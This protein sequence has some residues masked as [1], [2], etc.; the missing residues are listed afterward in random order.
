[1]TLNEFIEKVKVENNITYPTKN[2]SSYIIECARKQKEGSCAVLDDETVKNL[3]IGYTPDKAPQTEV[4]AKVV[5]SAD[6][7]K[8]VEQARVN[9][10]ELNRKAVEEAKARA[11]EKPKEEKKRDWEQMG[12]GFWNV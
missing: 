11:E 12:L 1:M 9:A 8:K 6:A 10:E 3:I 7:E 2:I 4:K 5:S